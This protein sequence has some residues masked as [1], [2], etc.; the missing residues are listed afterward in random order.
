MGLM[1]KLFGGKLARSNSGSGEI[2][3]HS[4]DSCKALAATNNKVPSPHNADFSS[5]RSA[6]IIEKPA[7]FNAKQAAALEALAQEREAM[8]KSSTKAYRALTR[9]DAA[10]TSVHRTHRKYQGVVADNEVSKLQSNARLAEKLHKQR[11]EYERM[12]Q[13]VDAAD[14]GAAAAIAAIRQSYGS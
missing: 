2:S 5:I 10:D 7:Y 3:G 9:V 12:G 4:I 13:R 11:P 6:P 8:A 14:H 1:T